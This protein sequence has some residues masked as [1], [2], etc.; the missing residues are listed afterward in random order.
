MERELIC[1]VC[2]RGCRLKVN[3]D[4]KTVTGNSCKRGEI[5]GINEVTSPVRVITSTVK[6]NGAALRMLPVKTDG[7]IPKDLN[8]KCMEEIAKVEVEAPIKV[9]Q[10]VIENVLGTGINVV[11]A[12]TLKKI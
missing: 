7:A 3:V 1:I 6:I 8:F 11:A 12:R 4:E 2:P 9:G 10:V 5:Y